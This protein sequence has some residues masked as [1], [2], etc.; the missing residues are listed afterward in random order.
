MPDHESLQSAL[1]DRI[2]DYYGEQFDENDRLVGRS[3][4][5]VLE[6]ERT[7]ELITQRVPPGSRIIDV[8]GATGIHAAPL[9]ARGDSVTLIDPVPSHVAAAAA[10]GT[11][12]AL[13]GDARDLPLKDA[14][15]DAVLLL[16][17]LYHLIDRGDRV[18]ALR[19][20]VRVVRPGG[21]VFAAAISRTM[22]HVFSS[23]IA[24]ATEQVQR[25]PYPA[26]WLHLLETGAT[27]H[28]GHGFPGG[29]FHLSE[30]LAEELTDGGL[31]D[32]EVHGLEGPGGMALEVARTHDD[33][34]RAAAMLLARHFGNV[35]GLRDLSQHLLAIGRRPA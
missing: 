5:G 24:V 28:L 22:A 8:G 29:H 3:D 31:V 2:M 7:Q 10:I 30:E 18:R 16:G 15:S 6:F 34:L 35:A 23:V 21:H 11:F 4:Q 17:P 33:E 26:D 20:A 1:D 14:T 13:V 19:E 32:V 27:D 9:A 25:S 12:T